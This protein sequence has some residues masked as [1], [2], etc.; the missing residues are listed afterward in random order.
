MKKE[1]QLV[2]DFKDYNKRQRSLGL[3][4]KTFEDY[5]RYRKGKSN[6]K[7]K[8]IKL[9][10]EATTFRRKAPDYPSGAGIGVFTGKKEMIYTGNNLLGIATMHKSNMVPVFKKEDAEDIANM[11][12]N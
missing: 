5:V 4:D 11:R 10:H 9:S 2:R 3:E 1:S 7:P 6:Y 12:R 8:V